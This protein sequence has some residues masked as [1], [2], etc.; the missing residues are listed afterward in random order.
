MP[1]AKK[2]AILGSSG[3]NLFH[4]GGGDPVRLLNEIAA[5]CRGAGIE[6]EAALFIAAQGSMDQKGASVAAEL[7]VWEPG[8]GTFQRMAQGDLDA[9]NR[10]ASRIDGEIARQIKE[11]RIDG[12]ILISC[13]PLGVNRQSVAAAV[14]RKLPVAGTGGTSMGTVKSLGASVVALSGTT[15]TT[16]LTRAVSFVLA[17][18]RHWKLP[19][20]MAGAK[21]WREARISGVM[22]S[23][24]PA[25]MAALLMMSLARLPALAALQEA[26]A[27]LAA[28]PGVIL[29]V[30][31][32]RHMSELGESTLIAG[33]VAGLLSV[34]GGV[35]GAMIAGLAA[36]WLVPRMF[37]LCTQRHFPATSVNIATAVFSGLIPGLFM[38]YAGNA[39]T[40]AAGD[41]VRQALAW[42]V[43]L[44]PALIGLAFGLCMWPLILKGWYHAVLLPLILIEMEEYGNSWIGALDMAGLVMTSAGILLAQLVLPLHPAD[45]TAAR[46]PFWLNVGFGTFI[47]ASYVYMSRSKFVYGGAIAASGLAGAVIGSLGLKSTAYVPFF[48]AML[49][50]NDALGFLGAMLTALLFAFTVGLCAN[51]A[52][53]KKPEH[54][55]SGRE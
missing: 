31:A 5:Q 37:R 7:H 12:L 42:T 9:V 17:L 10:E 33:A 54:S 44:H 1:T 55:E 2:V 25:F 16:N 6:V 23:S 19:Y 24:I 43:G 47:E 49:F 32:A 8:A 52:D 14:K 39:W 26:A 28:L 13:D 15:G 20:R 51:W 38:L 11:G 46:K 30:F 50:S 21:T 4:S 27:I 29:A 41:A 22:T 3:G 48:L 45:R 34:Q 35:I 40:M 18:S 36:G 53:R